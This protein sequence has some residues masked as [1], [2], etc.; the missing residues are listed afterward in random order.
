MEPS[1]EELGAF[2]PRECQRLL[3]NR[4][5]VDAPRGS[6]QGPGWGPPACGWR[7]GAG[8]T[9]WARSD[10]GTGSALGLLWSPR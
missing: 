8:W 2:N 7:G 4:K 10:S 5:A 1:D 3:E 6:G 9:Q